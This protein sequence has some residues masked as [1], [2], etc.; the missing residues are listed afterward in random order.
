MSIVYSYIGPLGPV[1]T[2]EDRPDLAPNAMGETREVA[3]IVL[4][5]IILHILQV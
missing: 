5:P 2:G 3:T 1:D 4:V